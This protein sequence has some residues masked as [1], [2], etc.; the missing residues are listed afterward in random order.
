MRR[1]SSQHGI[2]SV[3]AL[4]LWSELKY[5]ASEIGIGNHIV[6]RKYH[7]WSAFTFEQMLPQK[8]S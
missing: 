5:V 4:S 3:V 7:A 2:S 8:V 6:S 1:W